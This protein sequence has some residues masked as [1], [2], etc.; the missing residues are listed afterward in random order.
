MLRCDH[1]RRRTTDDR[2]TRSAL[3]RLRRP[4]GRGTPAR[5]VALDGRQHRPRRHRARPHLAARRRRPRSAAVRRRHGRAPRRARAGAAR[6]RRHGTRRSTPRC[7]PPTS[8]TWSWPS[9]PR[10]GGAPPAARGCEPDDA[11]KKVVWSEVVVDGGRRVEI[12]L[13]PLPAVPGSTRTA[14]AG[15]RSDAAAVRDRL[16]GARAAARPAHDALAPG[17]RARHRRPSRTGRASSTAR[18]GRALVAAPR[19]GRVVDGVDRAVVRRAGD[20]ALGRRRTARS[21]R[22]RRGAAARRG[23]AGERRRRRVPRRRRRSIRR[24]C[25]RAPRAS[26]R[27]PA[28][29]FRLVLSGRQR[30]RRAAA[31]GRRRAA[32]AGA[33]PRRRVPDLGV[34]AARRRPRALTPRRRP[35]SASSPTTTPSTPTRERMPARST[36]PR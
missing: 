31:D 4:A 21:T 27:S 1:S 5:L 11:M 36:P 33:A 10:R 24:R 7:A 18:S 32:A 34:R 19:S 15:A 16:G 23:A 29:R 20:G 9:R 22:L 6:D 14:R 3:E 30:G 28:R 13:P 35:G 2:R 26:R 17:E 8:S 25:R 12:A